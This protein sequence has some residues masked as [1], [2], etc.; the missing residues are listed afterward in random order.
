MK[1]EGYVVIGYIEV[2]CSFI[3]YLIC[4]GI[5]EKYRANRLKLEV[6]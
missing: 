1:K 6:F 3:L 2:V 5:G 4:S